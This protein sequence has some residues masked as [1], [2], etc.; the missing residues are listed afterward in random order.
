MPRGLKRPSGVFRNVL[1]HAHEAIWIDWK[2]ATEF[3]HTGIRGGARENAVAK[4]LSEHIPRQFAVATGEAI[5]CFDNRTSQLDIVIYDHH[6]N[7]PVAAGPGAVLL[8]AEALLAVI[9]VKSVLT[10]AELERCYVAARKLERLRPYKSK[11]FV[12]KRTQG[13][14]ADSNPRCPYNVIA[15]R[16]DLVEK[17]WLVKEW[18]RVKDVAH[19]TECDPQ[20]IDSIYVVDRGWIIPSSM[21]GKAV[22]SSPSELFQQWLLSIVNFL[23]RENPRREPVDWQNYSPRSSKGWN[24][25]V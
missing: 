23:S 9:E 15:F 14:I 2:K 8:P 1:D 13:K 25:L 7:C 21:R 18:Q 5:D 20:I 3:D 24:E 12:R 4:Y 11:R 22:E 6:R 19:S 10:R 16:S 17:D